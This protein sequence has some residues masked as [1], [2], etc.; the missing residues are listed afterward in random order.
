MAARRRIG[1]ED[2]AFV[3]NRRTFLAAAALAPATRL[4]MAAGDPVRIGYSMC[5]TGLFA[6]AAPSQVNA[7]SSSEHS[8]QLA[9]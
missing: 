6:Q 7:C 1:G 5:L 4:A 3:I 9:A 2:M 8:A